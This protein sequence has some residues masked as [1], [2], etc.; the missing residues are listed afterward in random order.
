MKVRIKPRKSSSKIWKKAGKAYGFLKREFVKLVVVGS[1]VLSVGYLVFVIFLEK[2]KVIVQEITVP[3]SLAKIGLTPDVAAKMI[4]D[5]LRHINQQ[6]DTSMKKNQIRGSQEKLDIKIKLP[7]NF[8][9]AGDIL[10]YLK[11]TVGRSDTYVNGEIIEKTKDYE[12]RLVVLNPEHIATGVFR[13]DKHEK[14]IEILHL[15]SKDVSKV[16]NPYVYTIYVESEINEQCKWNDECD[17]HEVVILFNEMINGG[18]ANFKKWAMLGYSVLAYRMKNYHDELV[19]CKNLIDSFEDFSLGYVNKA[20]ALNSMEKYDEAAQFCKHYERHASNNHMFYWNW[21]MALRGMQ[22]KEAYELAID[23]YNKSLDIKYTPEVFAEL[24][25]T[26]TLLEKVQDNEF[27]KYNY[28]ETE[29]VY[30]NLDESERT[31]QKGSKLFPSSSY[32]YLMWGRALMVKG[33]TG[34]AEE[35]FYKAIRYARDGEELRDAANEFEKAGNKVY[36]R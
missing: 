29:R 27:A 34:K 2:E 11:D 17:Y 23:K 18:N 6:A 10:K 28:N 25:Y 20:F 15:A 19:I 22:N 8:E 33:D 9:I 30:P 16:I 36:N 7:E 32:L 35:K 3:D 24:G 5:V 21:A 1:I 12:V 4:V 31:F 14:I 26:H 13:T